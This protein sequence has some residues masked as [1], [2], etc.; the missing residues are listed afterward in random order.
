MNEYALAL[1]AIISTRQ[2]RWVAGPPAPSRLADLRA[3]IDAAA[4]ATPAPFEGSLIGAAQN[5][6]RWHS[7]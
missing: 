6:D 2:P 1:A 3:A 5:L 4:I 7:R